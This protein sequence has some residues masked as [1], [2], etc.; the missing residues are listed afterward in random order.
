VSERRERNVP[1][2]RPKLIVALGDFGV[3]AMEQFAAATLD[4]VG[5]LP[6]HISFAPFTANSSNGP[7]RYRFFQRD[8]ASDQLA[9]DCLQQFCKNRQSPAMAPV[10]EMA[11]PVDEIA[12]A[13]LERAAEL[14]DEDRRRVAA[15]DG[16]GYAEGPADLVFLV[17]QQ[18][19]WWRIAC[20]L[21]LECGPRI[22]TL[23][24]VQRRWPL[25]G[26][27][28]S[29]IQP[30]NELCNAL[31]TVPPFTRMFVVGNINQRGGAVKPHVQARIVAGFLE[32]LLWRDNGNKL[33][34]ALGPNWVEGSDDPMEFL[35]CLTH[36]TKDV[37]LKKIERRLVATELRLLLGHPATPEDETELPASVSP[38]D[39]A[40]REVVRVVVAER[41]DSVKRGAGNADPTPPVD[42]KAVTAAVQSYG[43]DLENTAGQFVGPRQAEAVTDAPAVLRIG[44]AIRSISASQSS[45]E[46]ILERLQI[47]TATALRAMKKHEL[48]GGKGGVVRRRS[49][50]QN[51]KRRLWVSA[52][53]VIGLLAVAA[54]VAAVLS[55]YWMFVPAAVLGFAAVYCAAVASAMG[56]EERV[57]VIKTSGSQPPYDLELMKHTYA[58]LGGLWRRSEIRLRHLVNFRQKWSVKTEIEP[59]V[60]GDLASLIEP[61]SDEEFHRLAEEAEEEHRVEFNR[62]AAAVRNDL[63]DV[64]FGDREVDEVFRPLE[65][66]GKQMFRF[67]FEREIESLIE[68]ACGVSLKQLESD[69]ASRLDLPWPIGDHACRPCEPQTLQLYRRDSD[70]AG[71]TWCLS[72]IRVLNAAR[73]GPPVL[74]E[75]EN[76]GVPGSETIPKP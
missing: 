5:E 72:G 65:E 32:A 21:G 41:S 24:I 60:D 67:L 74:A 62:S 71:K 35:L 29:S 58:E 44:Q 9:R 42:K 30:L 64:V 27:R 47:D 20:Q 28:F 6:Y 40:L 55:T 33:Q 13:M 10:V 59:V 69:W 1:F 37:D 34:N 68:T 19:A 61:L 63:H 8:L 15:K 11:E 7:C 16:L 50:T 52:S 26:S 57:D 38:S 4:A 46:S 2:G 48:L 18:G 12:E 53:V 54:G 56:P 45:L 73:L 70:A 23:A 66:A 3:Y 76:G 36:R 31:G 22:P 75:G 25:S 17:D 51:P 39:E 49:T 43:D 14:G